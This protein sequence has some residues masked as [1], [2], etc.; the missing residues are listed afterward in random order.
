MKGLILKDL[1]TVFGYRKQYALVLFFMAIW[2][3]GMK[4]TGLISMYLLILG[5]MLVLSSLSTD[6]VSH[7]NR[8]ALTMPI[9]PKVLV[10]SKYVLLI[11]VMSLGAVIS[12]GIDF[13][14]RM[15]FPQWQTD[16]GWQGVLVTALLFI[17]TYSVTL[18]LIYKLCVEKARYVYIG[19]MLGFG[20]IIYGVASFADKLNIDIEKGVGINDF[21]IVLISLVLSCIVLMISY[22]CSLKV[23]EKKEW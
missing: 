8:L 10:K 12:M 23:I 15:L 13:I 20:I 22:L 7:F 16:L 17:A 21:V 2:S 6:E 3:V 9:S 1:Y 5:G 18:P 14:S 11:L 4:N 19:V